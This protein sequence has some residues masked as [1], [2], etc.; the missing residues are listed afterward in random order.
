MPKPLKDHNTEPLEPHEFISFHLKD[1]QSIQLQIF[2]DIDTNAELV[3]CDLCGLFFTLTKQ[4]LPTHLKGHRGLTKC[5]KAAERRVMQ[6]FQTEETTT[7]Q[8]LFCGPQEPA[9]NSR[10]PKI[11][12]VM[13]N[14]IF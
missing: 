13:N 7:R 10:T 3:Q 4:R 9:Q 14:Y 11:H 1:G 12:V 2:R 5:Q 8:G 6:R